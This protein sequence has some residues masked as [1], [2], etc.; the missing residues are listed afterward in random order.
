MSYVLSG[1]VI[2]RSLDDAAR[3]GERLDLPLDM[4]PLA[5]DCTICANRVR[6]Q[7]LDDAAVAALLTECGE[8]LAVIWDDRVGLR[9]SSFHQLS[10]ER[11][12]FG[13]AD[14]LFVELNDAGEPVLDGPIYSFAEIESCTED[15]EFETYRN[16]IELGCEAAGFCTAETVMR[17]IRRQG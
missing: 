9:A 1:V 11:L 16:A 4:L 10:G 6:E 5:D 14:E 12:A 7:I 2:P 13:D 15:K 17:F 8:L 3:I